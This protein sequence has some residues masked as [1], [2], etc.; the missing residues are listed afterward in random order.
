MHPMVQ[1]KTMSEVTLAHWAAQSRASLR[2]QIC[3]QLKAIEAQ[4]MQLL[5]RIKRTSSSSSP[6]LYFS[7]STREV[8]EAAGP[9]QMQISRQRQGTGQAFSPILPGWQQQQ[10]P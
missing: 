1:Q 2:I 8:A 10:P 3:R 9:E 5:H 7:L 4:K 6:S